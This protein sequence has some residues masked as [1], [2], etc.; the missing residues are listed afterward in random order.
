MQLL[1]DLLTVCL[2]TD[3]EEDVQFKQVITSFVSSDLI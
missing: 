3:I 1:Q 2:S